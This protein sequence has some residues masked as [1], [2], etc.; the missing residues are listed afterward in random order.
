MIHNRQGQTLIVFVILIPI[1]IGF[2]ALVID[3]GLVIYSKVHLREVTKTVIKDTIHEPNEEHIKKLL[4]DNNVD[5]D[6]LKIEIDSN[7]IV[8]NN[9][10]RVDSIFGAIIGFK[11]YKIK[12]AIEGR[13]ENSKVI[14]NYISG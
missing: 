4:K 13:I 7:K 10:F 3:T 12:V 6:N 11:E 2:A 9:E 1:L 8:I 14:F 5:I